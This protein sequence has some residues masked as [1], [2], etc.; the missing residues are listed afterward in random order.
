MVKFLY[1]TKKYY[2]IGEVAKMLGVNSS[3]LRF[4]EVQIDKLN[5]KKTGSGQRLYCEDDVEL[6]RTI[7]RELKDTGMTI[8]GL[9]KK[10]RIVGTVPDN[11]ID[12]NM[13][14]DIKNELEGILKVLKGDE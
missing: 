8:D 5:P 7:K 2:K 1:S 4:W 10:F 12:K 3:L 9:N 13:L 14:F 6:L 11:L